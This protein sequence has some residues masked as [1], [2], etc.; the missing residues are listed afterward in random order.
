MKWNKLIKRTLTD[1]EKE[2]YPDYDFMWD[3][4]VPD[5]QEMVLVYSNGYVEIDTWQ[6]FGP[7]GVG[8]ENNDDEVIYWM[9]LPDPPFK[10]V[11]DD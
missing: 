7:H 1:E 5:I 11:A 9:P 6:D 10:E 3:S 8:F 2:L 4:K